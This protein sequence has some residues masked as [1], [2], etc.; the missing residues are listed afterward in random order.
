MFFFQVVTFFSNYA[1]PMVSFELIFLVCLNW[2]I[3][4]L[5]ELWM[6]TYVWIDVFFPCGHFFLNYAWPMVSFELIFEF[7]QIRKF[8]Q[9]WN[10]QWSLM[11]KFM[12]VFQIEKLSWNNG[13][14]RAKFF[15]LVKIKKFL[16][17]LESSMVTNVWIDVCFSSGQFFQH[18]H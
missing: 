6:I 15:W 14:F 9:F 8:W 3:L 4:V 16:I 13:H 18:Y 10:R 7:V 1:W 11:F 17:V 2:N 5:L 12:F